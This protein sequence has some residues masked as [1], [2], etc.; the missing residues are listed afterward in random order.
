MLYMIYSLQLPLLHE[1]KSEL[2]PE[3]VP[4]DPWQLRLLVFVPD[5]HDFEQLPQFPQEA[6]YP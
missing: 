1:V 6:Q 3:H 2:D 5:P 4:R